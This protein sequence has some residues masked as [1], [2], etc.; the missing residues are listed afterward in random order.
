MIAIAS[1]HRGFKMKAEIMRYLDE[2]NIE[3]KDYGTFSEESV[4][5]PEKAK[6][7]A[8]AIQ[9]GKAEKGILI[10]GTGLGM[11]IAANKFKGIRCTVC[12]SEDVARYARKHNNSNILALGA[13]VNTIAEAIEIVRIWLATDFEGE[14]HKLRL[15]MIEEIENEN[16]K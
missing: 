9:K 1:D 6:D 2:H 11:S 4:D 16:F 3:Y 10:C 15:E 12:Y 14:R 8:L 7:V 5:Y 13:E